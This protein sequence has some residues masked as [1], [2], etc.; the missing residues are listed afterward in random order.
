MDEK[1]R[2]RNPF[3]WKTGFVGIALIG[4][5]IFFLLVNFRL[6]QIQ[7]DP[8][9]VILGI[10]FFVAGIIFAFFQGG[11]RGLFWLILPAG[12]SFTVGAIFLLLGMNE[13]FTLTGA[14]VASAGLGATFVLI[15]LLQKSQWWAL[16]PC[17]A[18][19]GFPLWVLV[20]FVQPRIGFHPVILLFFLGLAF[21]GI[22]F[23]SVQRQKMRF[24]LVTGSVVVAADVLYYLFIA[25]YEFNLF[26]AILLVA[27]GILLP[28][29][30]F[31]YDRRSA[32]AG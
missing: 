14:C 17:G 5:G 13:L 22:F 18:L 7:G 27:L 21:L 6:I 11:G 25:F 32:R 19:V 3:F 23:F 9:T 24:A 12:V 2:Q 29:L 8:V 20:A 31:I 1:I 15:F 28:F 10:L 4:S 16:L 26:W 30:F